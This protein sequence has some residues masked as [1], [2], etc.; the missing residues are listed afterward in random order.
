MSWTIILSYLIGCEHCFPLMSHFQS[1]LS[2]RSN[3][4]F[5]APVGCISLLDPMRSVTHTGLC[6]CPLRV[7]QSQPRSGTAN[8]PREQSLE[9]RERRTAGLN[10]T[11]EPKKNETK[12][13]IRAAEFSRGIQEATEQILWML[14]TSCPIPSFN[15]WVIMGGGV[16]WGRQMRS[17]WSVTSGSVRVL[18]PCSSG[19]LGP[20]AVLQPWH[21]TFPGRI[22]GQPVC[23]YCLLV[24][25]IALLLQQGRSLQR[26]HHFQMHD[27]TAT[28]MIP[29]SSCPA[30]RDGE[31]FHNDSDQ[32]VTMGGFNCPLW[33]VT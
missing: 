12:G 31:D 32:T 4:T 7:P 9:G 14:R 26:Q 15:I 10:W 11:Q 27:S 1:P 13:L 8:R 25:C 29:L 28:K 16:C 5:L 17:Y 33:Q 3:K 21:T 22:T 23:R 6:C 24:L 20:A 30:P 18:P 2:G 19:L